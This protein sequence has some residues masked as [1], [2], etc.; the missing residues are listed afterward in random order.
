M[1]NKKRKK[2]E[3]LLI[4]VFLFSGGVFDPEPEARP[5]EIGSKIFEISIPIKNRK[6]RG[7]RVCFLSFSLFMNR[8]YVHL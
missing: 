5:K 1:K 4:V 8:V 6:I 3:Q 7:N 2:K